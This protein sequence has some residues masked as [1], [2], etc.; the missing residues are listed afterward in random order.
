[1]I[2]CV[3]LPRFELLVALGARERLAQGPAAL[4][5]EPGGTQVIGEVSSAAQSSG[6]RRGMRL[7]EA[8]ARCPRLL[9]V[10]PDPASVA[11]RWEGVLGAIEGIGARVE[12]ARAGLLYTP[13]DELRRLHGAGCGDAARGDRVPRWLESVVAE[14]RRAIAMPARIGAGP[15]RFCAYA[16]AVRARARRLELVDE[17][18]LAGEPVELLRVRG[19]VAGIVDPLLR[20]G[21]GTLGEF[22]KLARCELADRFGRPGELAHDLARG[23]DHDLRPRVA[24]ERLRETMRLPESALGSQLERV[25]EL[26]IDRLL[27]RPEREGRSLRCLVLEAR[28]VEGGTWRE[29]VVLREALSDPRRICLALAPRL[30]RLPAP[31]EALRLSVESFGPGGG[32]ALTLL[33]EGAQERRSR[34]RSAIAQARVA[35]GPDAALRVVE[36]DPESRIPERRALLTPHEL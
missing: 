25:L 10:P 27:A 5:P 9:L 16:G 6:L 2:V 8:L 19:E 4:A 21:I 26:L 34:L 36:I 20:M 35:A 15:V 32:R 22:G 28:L 7:G 31:A 29:R 24:G 17:R 11:D 33:T 30:S 18:S 1:M 14:L 12:D 13:A 23:R 3:L